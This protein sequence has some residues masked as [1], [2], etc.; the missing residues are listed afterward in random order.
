MFLSLFPQW[1]HPA[2]RARQ[3]GRR[4]A[5]SFSP[6]RLECLEDRLVPATFTVNTTLDVINPDDDEL[7]L[8]E[9]I[10]RANTQAGADTIVVPAGVYRMALAGTGD[11]ANHRGD[12]D[13]TDSVTLQGAGAGATF[14]DAR[15]LDRIFDVRGGAAGPVQV[16]LQGLTG[17]GGFIS[18]SGGG[19][20]VG[21]NANLI[22][23]DSVVTG[24]TASVYGGGLS[25]AS[26]FG[27]S[28]FK[29]IRSTVSRNV[30]GDFG[31]GIQ[32]F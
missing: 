4:P 22:V 20:L 6:P 9:A 18:G 10:S 24:N 7:S 5:R 12:F 17:Q 8:R 19:I 1:W 31:G 16:T 13:I 23:R 14:I 21:G 28:N 3:P 27:M 15:K 29:L 26:D 11:D 2:P 25:N 32:M 30:A